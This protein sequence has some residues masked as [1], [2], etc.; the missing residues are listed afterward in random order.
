MYSDVNDTAVAP[1]EMVYSN[2]DFSAMK[3]RSPADGEKVQEITETE[4]AEIKIG[5]TLERQE[6]DGEEREVLEGSAEQE[7]LK[8]EDEEENQGLLA[9]EVVGEEFPQ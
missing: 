6:D 7:E 9:E 4:Y 3:E 2:I 5:E 1:K 8:E